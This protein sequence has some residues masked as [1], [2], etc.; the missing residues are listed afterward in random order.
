M[1]LEDDDS[2]S[3]SEE[4]NEDILSASD[5]DIGEEEVAVHGDSMKDAIGEDAELFSGGTGA[6]IPN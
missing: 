1:R 4:E 5:E 3:G 2:G 6:N